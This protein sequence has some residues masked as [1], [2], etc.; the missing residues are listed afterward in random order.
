MFGTTHSGEEV[1]GLPA[2]EVGPQGDIS[3]Y[4]GDQS[5]QVDGI[6]PGVAAEELYGAGIGAQQAE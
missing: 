2:G 5:V 4:V 3:R 1:D 6:D